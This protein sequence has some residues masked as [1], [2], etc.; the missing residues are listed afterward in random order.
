[1][2]DKRGLIRYADLVRFACLSL[3]ANQNKT[4]E[5]R[6]RMQGTVNQVTAGRFDFCRGHS[7]RS[8]QRGDP[9]H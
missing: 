7:R 3:R 2:H 1:M 8:N 6:A 4:K 9:E 5:M